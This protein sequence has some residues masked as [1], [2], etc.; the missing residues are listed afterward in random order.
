MLYWLVENCGLDRW[1]GKAG[2]LPN[3]K[4]LYAELS[5]GDDDAVMF[6]LTFPESI[7]ILAMG[8]YTLKPALFFDDTKF[9]RM[10]ECIDLWPKPT[11]S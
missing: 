11:R 8:E 7:T 10:P 3:F 6:K 2:Y 1:C 9:K 5:M 4:G